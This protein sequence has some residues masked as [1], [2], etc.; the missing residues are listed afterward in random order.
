MLDDR[1]INLAEYEALAQQ[2]LSPLA[3]DYY[4][5]GAMDEITLRD[6]REALD[7]IAIRYH[8]LAGTAE[9]DLSVQILGRTHDWPVLIAP[10]AFARL[11]HADGE[12][13]IAR[14]AASEGVTQVLSTLS[15]TTIEDV[16]AAA[17]G[18]HRWFQLYVF[19]DR[20][21]TTDLVRR[22]EA[23]G[24][25]GV[26]V[27]L[28]APLLGRRERDARNRFTLPEGLTAA[29]L[30]GPLARIGSDGTD[31][32]LF[33]FFASVLDPGLTWDDVEWLVSLTNLPVLVKG[34][35]RG[36]DAER[37]VEHGVAGVIVSNHGGRQLDTAISSIDALPEVAEA[38]DGR[39]AV[40]MDGGIRRGTDIV[41]AL[42]LGANGVL[43][44]RPVLW[45]L[46]VDG[47]AGVRHVLQLLRDELDLAMAL[48]GAS[49]VGELW[50]D[51]LL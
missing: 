46:A 44:G 43:I 18:G 14:A 32:G 31:S 1:P 12:A 41:K 37:A 21:L 10:T 51:L 16:A 48:C 29:N 23:A 49:N 47:E 11:A 9:R 33:Q 22:A 27:T 2:R 13:G 34:V 8:V 45:G 36:D 40:L 24:Y 7:R 26:V 50:P 25:D 28:D 39:A 20:G 17:P 38:V 15:T 30:A 35:V 6:N 19:K 5:S 42:A 4:S 3:W